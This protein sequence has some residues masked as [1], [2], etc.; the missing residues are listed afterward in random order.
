MGVNE[1]GY[2]SQDCSNFTKEKYAP[3]VFDEMPIR[4]ENKIQESYDSADSKEN[5][6]DLV[7][8]DFCKEIRVTDA[9]KQGRSVVIERGDQEIMKKENVHEVQVDGYNLNKNHVI[10]FKVVKENEKAVD[11]LDGNLDAHI[12]KSETNI[13][14][15]LSAKF[16][17][18]N[19]EIK[20]LEW[21][22]MLSFDAMNIAKGCKVHGNLGKEIIVQVWHKWKSKLPESKGSDILLD[23][24]QVM[25][26]CRHLT[27]VPIE[28]VC[29]F[30]REYTLFEDAVQFYI[31]ESRYGAKVEI[32]DIPF[33]PISSCIP[34]MIL[35]Y[36]ATFGELMKGYYYLDGEKSTTKD[37]IKL[38]ELKF[39]V[40]EKHGDL[41]ICSNNDLNKKQNVLHSTYCITTC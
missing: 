38:L 6:S 7:S 22:L 34:K 2:G 32:C 12:A 40:A 14:E 25:I 5:E 29:W 41:N 4:F 8:I 11:V 26:T 1:R 39:N 23:Q 30:M 9:V 37:D 28:V 17:R 15:N 36:D 35:V 20:E 16:D 3:K 13:I 27:L 10:A 18:R 24:K 33:H 21:M 19:H 31:A